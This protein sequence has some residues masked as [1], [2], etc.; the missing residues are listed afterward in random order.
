MQI[1]LLEE[2]VGIWIL[3]HHCFSGDEQSPSKL[4]YTC[5]LDDCG[6]VIAVEPKARVEDGLRV[7]EGSMGVGGAGRTYGSSSEEPMV[8]QRNQFSWE[9]ET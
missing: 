7:A 4:N 3:M 6:M 9:E 2:K 8:R 5:L 1:L